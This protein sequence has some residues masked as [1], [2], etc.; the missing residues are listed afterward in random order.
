MLNRL[1][2]TGQ[3]N[4]EPGPTLKINVKESRHINKTFLINGKAGITVSIS[5]KNITVH[6]Q[7]LAVPSSRLS[8]QDEK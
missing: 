5:L 6:G 8:L 1:L 7:Y 4:L 2:S 3:L